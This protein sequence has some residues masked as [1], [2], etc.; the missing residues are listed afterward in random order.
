M[1]LRNFAASLRRRSLFYTMSTLHVGVPYA[2]GVPSNQFAAYTGNS[3]CV[4]NRRYAFSADD[5]AQNTSSD[6]ITDGGH[7]HD[8]HEEEKGPVKATHFVTFSFRESQ[9]LD[10]ARFNQFVAAL[11]PEVFRMKGPVRF[12]DRSVMV[13]HV[14]G[15]SEIIAWPDGGDTTLA[16]IGWNVGAED[17]L[18]KLRECFA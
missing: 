3:Y 8:C 18:A 5:A 12:A 7:N 15:K 2:A 13:N 10:E 4:N 17:I 14:G 6:Y 16:F 1:G 9:E 11:P